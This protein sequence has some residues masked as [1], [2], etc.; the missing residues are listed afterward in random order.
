M[1]KEDTDLFSFKEIE[2]AGTR[3]SVMAELA[4]KR[5]G[6]E[7]DDIE[8]II[9]PQEVII[10][11][12]PITIPKQFIS[13]GC[14]S[15]HNNTRGPYKGGVRISPDVQDLANQNGITLTE[16]A[17]QIA[18]ERIYTSMKRRRMI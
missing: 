16:A 2:E 17:V 11:R 9:M 12:L 10:F 3:S 13:W 18:V 4:G 1:Y 6:L 5:M 14:I 15:L 7:E 8:A